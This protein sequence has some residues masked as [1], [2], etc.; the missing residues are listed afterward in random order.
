ML[1]RITRLTV[2]GLPR[3]GAD[4]ETRQCE[5]LNRKFTVEAPSATPIAVNDATLHRDSAPAL[6]LRR[7]ALP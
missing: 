3:S 7:S 5:A 1:D 6:R 2:R 4:E